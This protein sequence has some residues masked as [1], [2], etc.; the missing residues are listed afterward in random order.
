MLNSDASNRRG[1]E[2]KVDKK[3]KTKFQIKKIST[4]PDE[5]HYKW[6][7]NRSIIATFFLWSIY[8]LRYFSLLQWIKEGYRLIADRCNRASKDIEVALMLLIES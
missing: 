8:I 3:K 4:K 6:S 1:E 2:K 7:G 5:K